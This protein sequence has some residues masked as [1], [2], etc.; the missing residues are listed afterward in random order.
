M[1]EKE[2]AARR[3]GLLKAAAVGV[4]GTAVLVT[5][6]VSRAQTVTLR[7]QST[8]PQRDIFHEFA[9][10][11]VRRVNGMAGGRL[12]IDLLAGGRRGPPSRWPTPCM[13]ARSMAD[14]ASAAYWYGKHKACRC[15]ARRRPWLAS[16]SMIGW[17]YYGGGEALDQELVH[18]SAEA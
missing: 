4:A 3:R 9:Q 5:P 13:P 1:S 11:Y 17:F 8:W 2:P 16:Q 12:R 7:F 18:G 15:S 14:T 10:D 6:N